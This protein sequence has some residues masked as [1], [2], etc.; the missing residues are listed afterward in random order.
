MY[1]RRQWA[2]GPS[3]K[4]CFDEIGRSRNGDTHDERKVDEEVYKANVWKEIGKL[5][6][7][8]DYIGWQRAWGGIFVGA[9]RKWLF[10]VCTLQCS[11]CFVDGSQ[12]NLQRVT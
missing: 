5:Y 11:S 4:E 6:D 2:S 8:G 3:L 9:L 12:G 10:G 7:E 1:I